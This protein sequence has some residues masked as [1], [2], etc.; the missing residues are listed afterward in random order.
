MF[1]RLVLLVALASS[2]TAAQ[3]ESFIMQ[4]DWITGPELLGPPHKVFF[5][6]QSREFT[7]L[8]SFSLSALDSP[9]Y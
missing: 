7:S 2:A 1:K 8:F 3:A 6:F 4:L 5:A 9:L